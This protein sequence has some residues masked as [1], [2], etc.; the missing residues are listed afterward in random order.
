M[1]TRETSTDRGRRRGKM[2]L[3]RT[4]E[5][6]RT[7]RITA[8]VSQ[9][10]IASTLGWTHTDY[11]R[12]EKGLYRADSIS[13]VATVASVLGMEL[14]VG[15][16]PVGEPLRDKGH[17][18]LINRFRAE[19]SAGFTVI[20]EAPLPLL[21]DRRA[22]DLLLRLVSPMQ[23][24]IGV[25]AETRVRDLQRIVRHVHQR[26]RDG[27]ADVVLLLLAATRTNRAVVEEIRLALGPAFAT[28]PRDLLAA[29]RS[30][31]PLPGSGVIL[32]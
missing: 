28:P 13:D 16:H 23:Q 12:F 2:L 29:L 19:L 22:W 10:S 31:H 20:A 30:D 9:R 1:A 17:Q 8:D 18:A 24:L 27:G 32:V 26:V 5:E 4:I 3:T 6:L 15:L 14:S 7:A 21:G 11:Y 25:E